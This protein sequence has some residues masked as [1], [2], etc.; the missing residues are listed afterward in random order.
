MTDIGKWSTGTGIIV[1]EAITEKKD[2]SPVTTNNNLFDKKLVYKNNYRNITHS[3]SQEERYTRA[4]KVRI[5]L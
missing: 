4:T 1:K 5:L 3:T 2:K